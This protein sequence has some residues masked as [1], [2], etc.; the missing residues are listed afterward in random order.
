MM[1][2]QEAK[3]RCWAEIDFDALK[4]N[5]LE[6]LSLL[7]NG[8]GIICVLKANAYG[9]GAIETAKELYTLGARRFAVACM[10]EAEELKTGVNDIDVLVLGLVDETEAARAIQKGISL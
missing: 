8:A 3:A 10:A 4:S 6:A 1:T 7:S 5:Y 2:L 9:L